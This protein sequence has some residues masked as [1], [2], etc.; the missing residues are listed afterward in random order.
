[1]KNNNKVIILVSLVLLIFLSSMPSIAEEVKQ[2][3]PK[4]WYDDLFFKDKSFTFE[5]IRAL[6]LSVFGA[7]DIGEVVQTLRRMEEGVDV[8]WYNEWKKTADRIYKLA[9][10]FEKEG[11]TVSAREAYFRASMYYRSAGFYM[12]AKKNRPKALKTWK[13]SKESF[14][15]GIAS[16]DYVK[17]VKIPY[18][19]T[20]LPGYFVK[21]SKCKD[22]TPPLLIVQTGFDG[23]GEEI[24]FTSALP[25]IKRGYNCLVFEGPGQGA[26]LRLQNLHFRYDWEKVITPVV[27]YAISRPD[28]D[29]DKIALMGISMGGYLAPRGVAFE[30]RIKACI[31]NGGVYDFSAKPYS[32]PKEFIEMLKTNPDEFNKCMKEGMAENTNNRWFFNNGMFTFGVDTP[33]ELM[34]KIK[35]F[36]LKNVVKNI[37]CRMLVIR[38]E[39]DDLTVDAKK[40]YD[41]LECPKDY[42]VFTRKETAQAHCQMG[43]RMIGDEMIFNWLDGVFG[44]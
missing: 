18:E 27:D 32:M 14:L 42:L 21:T 24:F 2:E 41:E 16:L 3:G 26:A 44:K 19:N 39:A 1:M 29:K 15:K 11:H 20:T 9:Q 22:K 30:H 36:T 31:A 37:K 13:M 25:A 5:G 34:I 10:K 35:K 23:T 4:N 12:H 43:A 8:S 17:P 33:A 7:G 28:V 38:S 6:G 40:L